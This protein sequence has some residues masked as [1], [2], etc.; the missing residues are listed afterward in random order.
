MKEKKF[1]EVL[2]AQDYKLSRL[3]LYRLNWYVSPLVPQDMLKN[4]AECRRRGRE[5]QRARGRPGGVATCKSDT[6]CQLPGLCGQTSSPS[7]WQSFQQFL[8][9]LP[10]LLK[11]SFFQLLLPLFST[12]N[13]VKPPCWVNEG[14][15]GP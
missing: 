13:Q 2:V 6:Q 12:K 9:R 3:Y 8:P 1:F 11:V 5:L 4:V 7:E 14:E 15:P 10:Q